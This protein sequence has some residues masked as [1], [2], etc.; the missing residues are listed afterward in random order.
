MIFQGL[1]SC[2]TTS[3]VLTPA[4]QFYFNGDV[5][6]CKASLLLLLYL[7]TLYLLC[8]MTDSEKLNCCM[9]KIFLFLTYYL[10]IWS[11]TVI[12]MQKNVELR[13]QLIFRIQYWL[14]FYSECTFCYAENY[15]G[16]HFKKLTF[17][18]FL[19]GGLQ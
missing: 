10:H 12:P 16:S 19:S 6:F 4:L 15:F 7:F 13:L 18:R 8:R 5:P 1:L 2:K 17:N 9:S 3:K 14:T 11:F